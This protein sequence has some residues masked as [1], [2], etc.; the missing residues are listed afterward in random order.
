MGCLYFVEKSITDYVQNVFDKIF[1][2][3]ANMK[4]SCISR[5]MRLSM[6][7]QES[8]LSKGKALLGSI[9]GKY[10]DLSVFSFEDIFFS[11]IF[12]YEA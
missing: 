11:W 6:S 8:M 12:Y 4:Q 5:K 2:A 1:S 7:E 3:F 10:V 9:T